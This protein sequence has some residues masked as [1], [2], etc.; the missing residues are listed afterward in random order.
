MV[1]IYPQVNAYGCI[2][3]SGHIDRKTHT[4]TH[5]AM[6]NPSNTKCILSSLGGKDII[7]PPYVLLKVMTS[8]FQNGDHEHFIWG[9]QFQ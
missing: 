9:I 7:T 5:S 6:G 8:L 1:D 3:Y 2:F 4:L